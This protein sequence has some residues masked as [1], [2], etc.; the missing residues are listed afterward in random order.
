MMDTVTT[1]ET[2][3]ITATHTPPPTKTITAP[4]N[5][6]RISSAALGAMNFLTALGFF[7]SSGAT[8]MWPLI[9]IVAF[10]VICLCVQG[11]YV[12]YRYYY[13]PDINHLNP[14][15]P[16]WRV[17]LM[18]GSPWACAVLPCCY[19]CC[20]GHTL[21]AA[22]HLLL[23]AL[24]IIA[25]E[26]QLQLRGAATRFVGLGVAALVAILTQPIFNYF[27]YTYQIHDSYDVDAAAFVAAREAALKE[28][29]ERREAEAI[30]SASAQRKK[31]RSTVYIIDPTTED[32]NS[33]PQEDDTTLDDVMDIN[34]LYE[35]SEDNGENNNNFAMFLPTSN[36]EE[37]SRTGTSSTGVPVEA[38]DEFE[39]LIMTFDDD[40]ADMSAA[41]D[42]AAAKIE[43][44]PSASAPQGGHPHEKSVFD[45]FD[46]MDNSDE[47][48]ADPAEPQGGLHNPDRMLE[49]LIGLDF[50]EPTSMQRGGGA[51]TVDGT[52]N[53]GWD[54]DR[55]AEAFGRY[56]HEVEQQRFETGID[57]KGG[58]A[59]SFAVSDDET[60]LFDTPMEDED[61]RRLFA[62]T[63]N[64]SG[65]PV[66]PA[67]AP[68]AH[69]KTMIDQ[70]RSGGMTLSAGAVTMRGFLDA[71]LEDAERDDSEPPPIAMQRHEVEQR[72]FID[73]HEGE[74][75]TEL[76][77]QAA[78]EWKVVLAL[79]PNN[80]EMTAV[81]INDGIL[82]VTTLSTVHSYV[83]IGYAVSCIVLLAI[84]YGV[85]N[86]PNA[87]DVICGEDTDMS[88][89]V[90][91]GLIMD[92]VVQC[93]APLLVYL[94]RVLQSDDLNEMVWELHPYNGE[95]RL[96]VRPA[97]S[98]DEDEEH[99]D[100]VAEDCGVEKA[101]P[102]T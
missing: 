81:D 34:A 26:S 33:F 68:P 99:V 56:E 23:L 4:V 53:N 82:N 63:P 58:A 60:S 12:G 75:W 35:D 88:L 62:P 80:G 55:M 1:T 24:L 67:R 78:Q 74:G 66:P 69:M 61:A 50:V 7:S 27:F 9:F 36:E 98:N 94:F 30:A 3:N 21:H 20:I 83:T 91:Y 22:Q 96:T 101:H 97:D 72:Q 42:A 64:R 25:M 90:L 51:T 95:E 29:R 41:P 100:E 28:E 16:M 77:D 93:I 37:M 15:A 73:K 92:L 54:F 44:Q 76:L 86:R 38:E 85:L 70:S 48:T 31:R 10:I 11:V 13:R 46:E 5:V 32:K 39:P 43:Q 49:A 57:G 19:K 84:L 89:Q 52:T 71:V 79:A 102:I 6:P 18:S 65:P 8:C 40:F 17:L 47:M 2:H 59:F 45:L 87:D 14:T